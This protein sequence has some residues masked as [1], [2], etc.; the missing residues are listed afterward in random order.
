MAI[1]YA[2]INS[3]TDEV[4]YIGIGKTI[5]RA[6]SK[7]KRSKFWHDYIKMHPY[8]IEILFDN[9]SWDDACRKEI[10]LISYYGRRD[11]KEGTLVNLTNGGAGGDTMTGRKNPSLGEL[12]RARKG[13]PG[14]KLQWINKD[15]KN[16]RVLEENLQE[17]L[18]AGWNK[19]SLKTGPRAASK[20]KKPWN[21]GL[22]GYKV[23]NI[24]NALKG[25]KRAFYTQ[26]FTTCTHCKREVNATALIRFHGDKCKMK[27]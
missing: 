13:L 11:L 6:S 21:T 19:G 26:T 8:R 9:M 14:L 18:D 15:G 16:K 17:H 20:G 2:H 25:K 27:K 23:P 12:N 7:D 3:N 1:V 4:F 10:E 24:S 5:N 22:S